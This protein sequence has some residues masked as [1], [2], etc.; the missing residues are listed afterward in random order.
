MITYQDLYNA[1]RLEKYSEPL[2]KLPKNF[3]KEIHEYVTEKRSIISREG[4]AFTDAV[5]KISRQLNNAL[6]IVNE[7]FTIRSKKILNLAMLASKTGITKQDMQNMLLHEKKLFNGV[8]K[9]INES[10]NYVS[11]AINNGHEEKKDLKKNVL[12]RFNQDVPEFMD[13]DGNTLG[14]FK[15]SDVANLQ[16]D[17]ANI[18]INS[19]KATEII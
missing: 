15:S 9:S 6:T 19:K 11:N 17:I 10:V 13:S 4:K 1:L 16:R 7:L 8:T 12:I 2:Q 3:I 18:L 5:N 14:P